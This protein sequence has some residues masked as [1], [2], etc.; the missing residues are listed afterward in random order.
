MIDSLDISDSKKEKLSATVRKTLREN[1]GIQISALKNILLT[2]IEFDKMSE[3]KPAEKSDALSANKKEE[4]SSKSQDETIST[5]DGSVPSPVDQGIPQETSHTSPTVQGVPHETSHTSPDVQGTPQTSPVMPGKTNASPANQGVPHKSPEM[6]QSKTH[7]SPA[8][9]KEAQVSKGS[10]GGQQKTQEHA[11]TSQTD[12]GRKENPGHDQQKTSKQNDKSEQRHLLEGDRR[13]NEPQKPPQVN[14]GRRPDQS[15]QV[16]TLKQPDKSHEVDTRQRLNVL[17][18][19]QLQQQQ[20]RNQHQKQQQTQQ[21]QQRYQQQTRHQYQNQ[22]QNRQQNMQAHQQQNECQQRQQQSMNYRQQNQQLQNQRNQPQQGRQQANLQM[23]RNQQ[24]WN[25]LRP[26]QPNEQNLPKR[27]L[28]DLEMLYNQQRQRQNQ[29]KLNQQRLDQTIQN[30]HIR[31]RQDQTN[32]NMYN[33]QQPNRT[34]KNMYNQQQLNRTN[35]NLLQVPGASRL[36]Q[37]TA[38]RSRAQVRN[39]S[40]QGFR[41]HIFLIVLLTVS[42]LCLEAVTDWL[43]TD[44]QHS[45]LKTQCIWLGE[46]WVW[47]VNPECRVLSIHHKFWVHALNLWRFISTLHFILQYQIHVFEWGI[48]KCG[49]IHILRSGIPNQIHGVWS[50]EYPS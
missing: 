33:Q 10:L 37:M 27:R 39:D 20:A 1:P 48:L 15:H 28:S 6:D 35:Q 8:V 47:S 24:N 25:Q 2:F 3:N 19:H 49:R 30:M 18:Q 40:L 13:L 38:A 22:S 34:D 29:T 16:D 14:T 41:R 12:A 11:G 4:N 9:N 32:Q 31:Y 42:N 5:T 46:S 26:N 36:Q 21:H 43:M 44:T 50:A 23:S 17:R 45:T 7:V